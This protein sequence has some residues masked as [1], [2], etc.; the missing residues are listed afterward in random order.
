[1]GRKAVGAVMACYDRRPS[2]ADQIHLHLIRET[3]CRK[4]DGDKGD[5]SP[6]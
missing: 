6:H 1:M 4:G 3:G 2:G 5:Q